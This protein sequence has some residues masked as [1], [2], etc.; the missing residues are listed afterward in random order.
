[1][2]RHSPLARAAEQFLFLRPKLLLD[3]SRLPG[4]VCDSLAGCSVHRKLVSPLLIR[5][6][7]TSRHA[8]PG[9]R[10]ADLRLRNRRPS[11]HWPAGTITS[12]LTAKVLR[13]SQGRLYR[14]RHHFAA[15]DADPQKTLYEF[16]VLDPTTH[17]RTDCTVF[18]HQCVVTPYHP[19]LSFP[20][21]PV[22]SFANGTRVGSRESLG[23]KM[24]QDLNT[25]G[26]RESV[27]IAPG[28]LGNDKSL[29]LTRDFWYSPDLKTNLQ[30]VRT[31]PRDGTVTIQLNIDSRGE[32]D[33]STFAVPSGYRI[34][35]PHTPPPVLP[36]N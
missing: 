3:C 23:E 27:T 35:A 5:A 10:H 21:M 24:I 19:R 15:A 11:V 9:R 13:D 18:N 6:N 2:L 17:T 20:Q 1:M 14:E 22:G 31:D 4:G 16:Y 32:P 29:T 26:T 34:V 33:P 12:T 8:R 36:S 28:V 25:T 30:V 7:H